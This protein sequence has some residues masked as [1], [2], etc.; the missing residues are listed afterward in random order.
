MSHQKSKINSNS[1]KLKG[2]VNIMSFIP[3]KRKGPLPSSFGCESGCNQ[4]MPSSV[5]AIVLDKPQFLQT[6]K[7]KYLLNYKLVL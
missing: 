4:N 6:K 7:K 5:S 3:H 1:M 2:T